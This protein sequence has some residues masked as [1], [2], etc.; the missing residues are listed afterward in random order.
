LQGIAA[1]ALAGVALIAA[2]ESRWTETIRV[3]S[4]SLIQQ[5]SIA[6]KHLSLDGVGLDAPVIDVDLYCSVT[7]SSGALD[8]ARAHREL[9][10]AAYVV[11]AIRR[12]RTMRV[13]PT[14]LKADGDAPL[15]AYL[16]V[17]LAS[18]DRRA[19][20]FLDAPKIKMSDVQWTA[21]PAA[22]DLVAAY[23]GDLRQQGLTATVNLVCQIQSDRSVLCATT[24]PE[25]VGDD[26]ARDA[27]RQFSWAGKAIMGLYVAAPALK[28]GA[29][30][31]G[32]VIATSVEF[33]PQD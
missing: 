15:H 31:A 21:V 9:A 12:S 25:P 28:S 32:A 3:D 18:G 24:D 33:K 6:W 19:I 10:G 11:A 7:R 8:C 13:D 20:D 29:S 27:F 4:S 23:P 26:K 22:A 5:P 1:I 16:T 14:R 30:S 17:T 2:A